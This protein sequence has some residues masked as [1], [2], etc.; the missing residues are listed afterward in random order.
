MP[1]QLRQLVPA[2]AD[3]VLDLM[4]V[5]FGDLERRMGLPDSPPPADREPGLR[6]IRHLA[7]TDPGGAWLAPGRNGAP[8]GA[9]LALV[10]EGVWGLS[11]LVVRP[12]RQSDGIGTALLRAALAH[13]DGTRGGLIL[14][15]EDER[16]LRAYSRAGFALRPCVDA[17]G[18]VRRRPRPAP[19][20][21]PIRWPDDLPIVDEA[22]RFVRGA[23]HAV[24]VPNYLASGIDVVV[25]D[26]GG[27]AAADGGRV[28]V[29]AARDQGVAAELLRTLLARVP[30]GDEARVEF[31]DAANDWATRIAV[32]AG[33]RLRPAGAVFTR[34][35]VGPLSPY[36][37]SG[38]YL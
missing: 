30:D 9:A 35:E 13:G 20:V 2:D 22:S 27:W 12:G 31:I 29:V 8:D 7:R 38:A 17:D 14:A 36:V 1:P 37:P 3:A 24:D 19:A 33:L 15:S 28:R 4:H 32:D 34:G 21:R 11:L 25:H 10:R 5:T 23:T 16:A 18:P 26:G 6:R